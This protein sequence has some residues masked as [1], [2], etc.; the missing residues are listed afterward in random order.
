MAAMNKSALIGVGAIAVIGGAVAVL[1]GGRGG[2]PSTQA[3]FRQR[4]FTARAGGAEQ[5]VEG[6]VAPTY[7]T[8]TAPRGSSGVV[9]WAAWDQVR[10]SAGSDLYRAENLQ[11]G[12]VPFTIETDEGPVLVEGPVRGF[13]DLVARDRGPTGPVE[14]TLAPGDP[15]TVLG[16]LVERDGERVVGEAVIAKGTYAA[17]DAA[18]AT[19]FFDSLDP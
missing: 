19:H 7:A 5:V 8:T 18:L 13:T 3:V 15:V 4:L 12:G 1:V 17:W 10:L 6:R 2:G 9:A 11:L 14:V 16:T